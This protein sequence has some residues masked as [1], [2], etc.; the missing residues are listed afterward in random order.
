M[1]NG[2]TSI[3]RLEHQNLVN[4]ADYGVRQPRACNTVDFQDHLLL[5]GLDKV[6]NDHG[7]LIWDF[8]QSYTDS[9]PIAQ[10]GNSESISSAIWFAEKQVM[11]GMSLK[12]IKAF[13]TREP[14]GLVFSINTKAV[15]GL[16][17]DHF[18]QHQFASFADD[19]LIRIWDD[20]KPIDPILVINSE[21]KFGIGGINWCP[22]QP[23]LLGSHGKDSTSF[24]TWTIKQ[25]FAQDAGLEPNLELLECIVQEFIQVRISDVHIVDFQWVPEK[26]IT[27]DPC[28]VSLNKDSKLTETRLH[29]SPVNA[30]GPNGDMLF[31]TSET[32][33]YMSPVEATDEFEIESRLGSQFKIQNLEYEL[34][35]SQTMHHRAKSGYLVDPLLNMTLLKEANADESLIK[36]WELVQKMGHQ[37]STGIQGHVE[38]MRNDMS[39]VPKV[40]T[41]DPGVGFFLTTYHD[42]YR[43]MIL[44]WIAPFFNQD[45]NVDDY[46]AHLLVA[47][48]YEKAAGLSFFTYG[49]LS[50]AVDCLRVTSLAGAMPTHAQQNQY[51]VWKELCASL[52][53]KVSNPYL[54][55]LF[56][57]MATMGDWMNVLLDPKLT[58]EEGLS[59]AVRFLD[60]EDLLLF[61][62]KKTRE[63]IQRGNLQGLLL[64]GWSLSLIDLM[65]SFVDR[66]GDVQT[67][68]L[69]LSVRPRD[70]QH[71]ERFVNWIINYKNLLEKWQ[72]FH[73]RAKFDI[74]WR[75]EEIPPQVY[76]RCNFCN[77]SIAPGSASKTKKGPLQLNKQS[78]S[79]VCTNCRKPLPKCA[80]CLLPL[81]TATNQD[82]R[83][84]LWFTWC[85]TCRHGGHAIHMFDWFRGHQK[86]PVA[87][88]DCFCNHQ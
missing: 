37:R 69:V 63:M 64:T 45:V 66:T 29:S 53:T 55:I 33:L 56:G 81:G 2:R 43:E 32:V 42:S 59:V 82:S 71:D 8:G 11:A 20:R 24:K 40:K 83:F 15:Q 7:L 51:S 6:R 16:C 61:V 47:K 34:D 23:G 88:C 46:I 85:Q 49:D 19:S 60:N 75:K 67:A 10:F 18:N 86:C 57:L 80:L 77:T 50:K 3:V 9:G 26:G 28:F 36:C 74:L 38:N 73:C 44:E 70:I 72:L 13:D 68:V 12:F 30:I 54:K 79:S 35:I 4:L 25:R 14:K 84:D 22:N 76:I 87:G 78:G 62:N 48:E 5:S 21:F 52:R 27:S 17:F 41:M 58:L 1:S 65:Q 31:C 39:S